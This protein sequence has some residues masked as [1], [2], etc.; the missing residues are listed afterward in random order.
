MPTSETT[1]AAPMWNRATELLL[2]WVRKRRAASKCFVH[3][4]RGPD[5]W[6]KCPADGKKGAS[7]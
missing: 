6:G 3:R 5:G 1:A 4:R 7:S 2:S